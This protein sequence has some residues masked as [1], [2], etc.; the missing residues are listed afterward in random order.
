MV[1]LRTPY[2]HRRK[3]NGGRASLRRAH[4][5]GTHTHTVEEFNGRGK[6]FFSNSA[7]RLAIA[8]ITIDVTALK[9]G[10]GGGGYFPPLR[11][12][13]CHTLYASA[14]LDYTPR[15]RTL[16]ACACTCV[17]TP[18][19]FVRFFPRTFSCKL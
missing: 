14:D 10:D 16:R 12:H 4:T 18:R 17:C 3:T 2:E 9:T 7:G 1:T 5:H 6:P 8:I 19:P 13:T 11:S 15:E